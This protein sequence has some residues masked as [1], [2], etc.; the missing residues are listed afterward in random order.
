MQCR[1]IE[2]RECWLVSRNQPVRNKWKSTQGI[3][4]YP[5]ICS[6]IK[7]MQETGINTGKKKINKPWALPSRRSHFSGRGMCMESIIVEMAQ[8]TA[9][10]TRGRDEKSVGGSENKSQGQIWATFGKM[11]RNLSGGWSRDGLLGRWN[12]LSKDLEA[13]EFHRNPRMKSHWS[14]S[15]HA[16]FPEPIAGSAWRVSLIRSAL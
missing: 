12:S 13:S 4:L 11:S 6:F 5:F 10:V 8:D 7:Y 1:K 3:F 9:A 15:V 16:T 14:V 2:K